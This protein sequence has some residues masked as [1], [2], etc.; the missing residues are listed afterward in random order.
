MFGLVVIIVV[1][2][3]SAAVFDGFIKTLFP[4]RPANLLKSHFPFE[5]GRRCNLFSFNPSVAE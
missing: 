4:N 3:W 5:S 1:A 2:K